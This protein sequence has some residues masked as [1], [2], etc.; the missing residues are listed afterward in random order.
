M[1]TLTESAAERLIATRA[2]DCAPP[3]FVGAAIDL[4]GPAKDT[5]PESDIP[6]VRRALRHGFIC[7][8]PNGNVAVSGP[9]SP[10]L[11]SCLARMSDDLTLLTRTRKAPGG[12]IR[13]GLEAGL[14]GGG[15]LG[16]ARRWRLAHTVAPVLAAAFANT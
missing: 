14:D 16:L 1:G 11:D 3:G 15:P 7:V 5:R 12:G 2:F 4:R 6:E 9:P 10:G 8:R 13:I